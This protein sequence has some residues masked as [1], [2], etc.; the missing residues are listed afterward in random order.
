MF[1]CIHFPVWPYPPK[2][3]ILKNFLLVNYGLTGM[4]MWP[5]AHHN[6]LKINK[7]M[8]ITGCC[9]TGSDNIQYVTGSSYK[10]FSVLIC[11][12]ILIHVPYF[13]NAICM[14]E[15]KLN[16]QN[17]FKLISS[18]CDWQTM[19]DHCYCKWWSWFVVYQVLLPPPPTPSIIT[20]TSF[21]VECCAIWN[22]NVIVY[23]IQIYI[24]KL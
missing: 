17:F 24:C 23:L 9:D 16:Y 6:C 11:F 14:I 5:F 12:S 1:S 10:C 15:K 3:M 20:F 22:L 4:G 2:I 18:A 19:N 13:S 7:C 21:L 8:V